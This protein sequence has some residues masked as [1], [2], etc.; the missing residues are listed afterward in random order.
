MVGFNRRF[1]PYAQEAKKHIQ[2]RINPLFMHYRVNAGY[3]PLD[4]WVHG[5]EGGGR[6]IGEACHFIDLFTFFAE[7]KVKAIY[8][9][10]LIPKTE[11]LSRDDHRVIVLNYED[12]SIATLEYFASGSKEFSK[13]Y[14]E[15]HFDEKTIVIDDFKSIKG[16][17]VK[18]NDIRSKRFR[19]R[20]FEGVG[21]PL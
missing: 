20:T 11:S 14:F 2:Q 3:I 16:Y 8:T 5:E 6:I 17:G 19:K 10:T 7:C 1:S 13:E 4:H 18:I 9:S 15:I 12:G 21:G